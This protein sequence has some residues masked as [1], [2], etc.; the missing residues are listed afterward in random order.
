MISTKLSILSNNRPDWGC[1]TDP[2]SCNRSRKGD[3]F[4]GF[5]GFNLNQGVTALLIDFPIS[6]RILEIL[7]IQDD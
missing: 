5:P 2:V 3:W 7:E 4:G 6:N 1:A